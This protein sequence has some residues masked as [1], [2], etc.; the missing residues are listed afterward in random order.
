MSKRIIEIGNAAFLR[1]HHQQLVI[2]KEK[3]VIASIP[4]EDMAAL[5]LSDPQVVLTHAGLSFLLENQVAV[6]SCDRRHQPVGLFLPLQG[7]SLQGE[8]FACQW[9]LSKPARKRIWKEV[10]SAKLKIQAKV[11]KDLAGKENISPLISKIR[12][13]DPN[14][15]EAQAARRYWKLLFPEA[16][17]RDRYGDDQNRFLNYGYAIVRSL[18]ARSIC[19]AGLHPGIGIHHRN[20]YNDFPLADDLMEPFRPFVDLHVW[21][22]VQDQGSD[23]EMTQDNRKRLIEVIKHTV[24]VQ[25]ERLT[26]QH[27]V[28]KAAQSLAQWMVTGEKQLL[29][30]DG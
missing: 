28:Q 5:V 27:A 18:V 4:V 23:A 20:R 21:Q 13:G 19:A 29:L 12:S 6:I 10:I 2:E 7:N 26:L 9:A 30:P 1:V 11:A 3:Q 25:S 8:R 22:L 24:S 17:K 15:I 16:F 14:N